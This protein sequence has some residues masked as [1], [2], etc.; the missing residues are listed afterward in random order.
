M[1]HKGRYL[2]GQSENTHKNFGLSF[3]A[4]Y[5]LWTVRIIKGKLVD[6]V[7]RLLCDISYTAVE[8]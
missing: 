6:H 5:R 7:R 3:G 2:P 1:T 8:E 4:L